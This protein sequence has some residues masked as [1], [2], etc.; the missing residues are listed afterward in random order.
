M[1]IWVVYVL[2]ALYIG[3]GIYLAKLT[4]NDE[5]VKD[6]HR[7]EPY[8]VLIVLIWPLGLVLAIIDVIKR[9]RRQR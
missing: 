2:F 4:M 5:R 6:K 7:T 1:G 9:K 8:F 3:F